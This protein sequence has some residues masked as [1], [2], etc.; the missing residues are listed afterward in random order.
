MGLLDR[1]RR[2]PAPAATD[3]SELIW[4]HSI[5]LGDGVVTRGVKSPE[6]LAHELAQY[7][8]PDLDGRSVL[9]VGAWDG[10]FSFAVE[11][12]GATRVVALDHYAWSMDLHAQH[13]YLNGSRERG[14]TP[15]PFE[16]VP[17]VWRPR[18][19][20]G[21]RGFDLARARLGSRVQPVV[22]DLMTIDLDALG[23]FDV[24]L[25]LGVLYHMQDPFAALRRLAAVTG[26]LAVIET[27]AVRFPALD[28]RAVWEFFP[29]AELADDPSNWWVPTDRALHGACRAAGF[30]HVETVVG[31]PPPA[32][33][34]PPAVRYRGVVHARR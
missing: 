10:Y 9:D 25:Y 8:L 32:A 33:D 5:D 3:P 28:D 7:R 26:D 1:L 22:G 15:E 17:E 23:R 14:E 24:V 11:R 4:F 13:A 6:L 12:L 29:G 19:L 34:D 31:P 16:R 2:P 20:P 21:K 27:E 18:E 30:A